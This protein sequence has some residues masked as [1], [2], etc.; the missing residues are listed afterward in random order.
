[1]LLRS[2]HSDMRWICFENEPDFEK[3][4]ALQEQRQA[5]VDVPILCQVPWFLQYREIGRLGKHVRRLLD[6][7]P[8]EQI[9]FYLIDDLKDSSRAVYQDTLSFLGVP[10]DGRCHFPRVNA[11]KRNRLQGLAK[12]Q[13]AVVRALPRSCIKAGKLIGLGKLNRTITDL[14]S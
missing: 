14:N 4:W 5:G 12:L 1:D 3:A 2:F 13:S 7:F 6:L 9:R 10:D 11:S 8:R